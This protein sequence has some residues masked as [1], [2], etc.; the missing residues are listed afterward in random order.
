MSKIPIINQIIKD[1]RKK[2]KLTQNEFAKIINKSPTTVKRYDTGDIIPQNTLILICDKLE[3]DLIDL[4]IEQQTE[5]ETS[6]TNFYDILISKYI[7]SN[8]IE[9][10]LTENEAILDWLFDILIPYYTKKNLE[11]FSVEY[12][13]NKYYV[14]GSN[15]ETLNIFTEKQ[16]TELTEHIK[17][18]IDYFIFKC[19]KENLN[20]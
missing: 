20:K 6:N 1:K 15:N 4:F 13:D 16:V 8:Q 17:D 10:K 11:E 2:L 14:K 7:Q 9:E 5:N 19:Q 3:L 12:S 18:Y